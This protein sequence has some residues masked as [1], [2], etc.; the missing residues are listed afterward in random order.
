MNSNPPRDFLAEATTLALQLDPVSWEFD[1]SDREFDFST[2]FTAFQQQ[3]F[4][5]DA[6]L[7]TVSWLSAVPRTVKTAAGIESPRLFGPV[8]A[9]NACRE[10]LSKSS[11]VGARRISFNSNVAVAGT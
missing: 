4:G 7:A 1:L 3:Q 5:R 8:Q 9:L 6:A 11:H 2:R 10:S